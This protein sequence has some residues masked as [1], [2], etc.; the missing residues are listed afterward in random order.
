MPGMPFS[1]GH[2][3]ELWLPDG[4]QSGQETRGLSRA[5]GSGYDTCAGRTAP[6]TRMGCHSPIRRTDPPRSS[7]NRC[8]NSSV[9]SAGSSFGSEKKTFRSP[10][11]ITRN[12]HRMG[13]RHVRG[14]R[15]FL[16]TFCLIQDEST[17]CGDP[18]WSGCRSA[19]GDSSSAMASS[20]TSG[21][22]RRTSRRTETAARYTAT[23]EAPSTR[24]FQSPDE[25]SRTVIGGLAHRPLILAFQIRM[26]GPRMVN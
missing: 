25:A 15:M 17:Y 2:G 26:S 6:Q 7:K 11:D 8:P 4:V 5:A 24:L 22:V 16:Q 9:R 23:P 19:I 1:H 10:A 21:I 20:I 3:H 18:R 13:C 14:T 12:D